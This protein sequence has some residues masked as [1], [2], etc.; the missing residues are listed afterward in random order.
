ML[1]DLHTALSNLKSNG[2]LNNSQSQLADKVLN[3]LS[4]IENFESKILPFYWELGIGE[5]CSKQQ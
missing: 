5:G 3:N 1:G 4:Q 2:G